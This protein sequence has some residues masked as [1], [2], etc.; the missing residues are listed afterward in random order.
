[1]AAIETIAAALAATATS[2]DFS[3]YVFN[4]F[5]RNIKQVATATCRYR[6]TDEEDE[7]EGRRRC[8]RFIVLNVCANNYDACR[9]LSFVWICRC[10]Q[11]WRF[12]RVINI[13]TFAK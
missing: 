2:V 8:V 11:V 5:K 12:E 4:D 10:M 1:M 13:L 7:E 3:N 6:E 9:V